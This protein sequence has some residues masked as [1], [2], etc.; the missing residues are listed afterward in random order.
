MSLKLL[1]VS[2][3]SALL[4]AACAESSH[5]HH[6]GMTSANYSDT[7]IAAAKDMHN[8]ACPVTGDQV[9]GSKVVVI[10]DGKLYHFCCS[11]CL[12]TFNDNPGK[13]IRQMDSN[14]EKFGIKH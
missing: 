14:P 13:Y 7:E 9:G 1:T 4:L 10:H 5:E 11:D 2:L 3:A 6:H 8:T 12:A